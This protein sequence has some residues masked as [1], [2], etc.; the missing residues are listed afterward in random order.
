MTLNNLMMKFQKGL[1]T[2]RN[3]VGRGKGGVGESAVGRGRG[4]GGSRGEGFGYEKN[5]VD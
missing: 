2:D 5:L 4:P 3:G 1:N